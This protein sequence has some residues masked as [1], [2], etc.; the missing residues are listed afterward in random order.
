MAQY[1]TYFKIEKTGELLIVAP[2]LED[3]DEL[4]IQFSLPHDKIL[5]L[6]QAVS[7][8]DNNDYDSFILYSFNGE[9]RIFYE[10]ENPDF[11]SYFT[12]DTAC[13]EKE[14]WFKTTALSEK[15]GSF[16]TNWLVRLESYQ[17]LTEELGE[18]N[19]KVR[20]NKL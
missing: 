6:Y 13:T 8:N 14:Y 16:L 18:Q 4:K 11:S 3:L 19:Q 10:Y 9:E 2:E 15:A 1:E 5:Y 20:K 17:Q 12:E 7:L